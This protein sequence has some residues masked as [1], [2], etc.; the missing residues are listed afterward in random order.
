MQILKQLSSIECHPGMNFIV[1]LLS[2]FAAMNYYGEPYTRNTVFWIGYM[3]W[4]CG[5]NTMAL[6]VKT[7]GMDA[8]RET[9]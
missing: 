7:G 3:M 9:D 4:I 1:M 5:V 2:F 6:F 8:T